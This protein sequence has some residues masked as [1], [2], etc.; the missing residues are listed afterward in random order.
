MVYSKPSSEPEPQ[1]A[2]IVE[3]VDGREA[4]S[5]KR[6]HLLGRFNEN[7]EFIIK[8][9]DELVNVGVLKA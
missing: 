6:N 2:R 5:P 8:R 1:P 3:T 7:G 4:R 9:G